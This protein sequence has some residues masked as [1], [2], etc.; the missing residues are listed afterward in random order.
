M[1]LVLFGREMKR[2]K[3]VCINYCLCMAQCGV[4]SRAG[5]VA[6]YCEKV[7]SFF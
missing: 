6:M 3:L 1:L 2:S 5:G 4:G 7:W